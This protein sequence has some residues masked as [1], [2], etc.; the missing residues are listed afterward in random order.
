MVASV[1]CSASKQ[2]KES[3]ENPL[4]GGLLPRVGVVFAECTVFFRECT[5]CRQ[6]Q[7]LIVEEGSYL[8]HLA[9]VEDHEEV[10]G[11]GDEPLR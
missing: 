7:R 4:E 9:A 5:A 3:S 8:G 1:A 11:G 6:L 10:Q 2:D